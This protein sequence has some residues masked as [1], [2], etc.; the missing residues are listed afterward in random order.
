MCVC[1][2]Y[3]GH[4]QSTHPSPLHQSVQ[5][6]VHSEAKRLIAACPA[7]VGGF[8]KTGL[9]CIDVEY[10]GTHCSRRTQES[11]SDEMC[12]QPRPS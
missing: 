2:V 9:H 6:S 7:V 5:G 11:T 8:R 3:T 4:G 1:A 12:I 10:N